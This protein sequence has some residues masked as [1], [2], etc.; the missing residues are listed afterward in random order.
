MYSLKDYFIKHFEHLFIT[1]VLIGVAC[2]HYFAPYKLAFLNFFFIPILMAGYFLGVRYAVSGAVFCVLMVCAS[3]ALNPEAFISQG[4]T[5]DAYMQVALWGGFLI[6]SGALV[7]HLYERL[8]ERISTENELNKELRHMQKEMVNANDQLR[9]YADNLES[10]VQDKT[11]H[12]AD[13]KQVLAKLK[14]KVEEVLHMTMDPTVAQMLIESK[15]RNEKRHISVLVADLKGFTPYSERRQ[16]ES[17]I[18]ELNRFLADMSTFTEAYRAHLDRYTGDGFMLEFGAPVDYKHHQLLAVT[19]GIRM[20]EFMRASEYPWKM[21]VGLTSGPAVVGLIGGRKRSYTVMGNCANT[22]SRLE[23]LCPPASML[24]DEATYKAVE[25]YINGRLYRPAELQ[26]TVTAA[27]ENEL[28]E[29]E[30]EHRDN[31]DDVDCMVRLAQKYLTLNHSGKAKDMFSLAMNAHPSHQEAKL[32]FAEACIQAE[33]NLTPIKGR[34]MRMAL[35]EVQGI[36]DFFDCAAIPPSVAEKYRHVIDDID[37]PADLVLPWEIISG[38]FGHA[39][40]TTLLAY[41]LADQLKIGEK[42]RKSLVTAGFLHDT[43]LSVVPH[44]LLTKSTA[45]IADDLKQIQRHPEESVR[46][47][48]KHGYKDPIALECVLNHHQTPDGAGYPQQSSKLGMSPLSRIM[49]IV[50]AYESMTS[51]RPWRD[52]W[53]PHGALEEMRVDTTNGKYDRRMFEVFEKM[54]TSSLP[55]SSATLHSLSFLNVSTANDGA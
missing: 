31:Q 43:G 15:L 54:I 20:M 51:E 10:M 47:M 44:S 7:G 28:K 17:V 9:E 27:A 36:R 16:P 52:K 39:A 23:G 2:I 12:L 8:D 6:T 32:G 5:W 50:D 11:A 21:R 45:L 30:Q 48:I 41:A 35:F 25:P 38:Q 29:L 1:V 22:A 18:Q 55:E 53:N 34:R 46:I 37:I 42:E 33:Q 49:A 24:I 19:C 26:D 14:G 13:S 4:N 3:L 40:R